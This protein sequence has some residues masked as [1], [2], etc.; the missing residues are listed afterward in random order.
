MDKAIIFRIVYSVLLIPAVYDISK[1]TFLFV[2]D[3]LINKSIPTSIS[4]YWYS[5]VESKRNPN[6]KTVEFINIKQKGEFVSFNLYQHTYKQ[7][8]FYYKG[9]GMMKGVKLVAWFS[10]QEARSD[11]IGAFILA[12]EHDRQHTFYL[13]GYYEELNSEH[14]LIGDIYST[15]PISLDLF[16]KLEFTFSKR[17]FMEKMYDRFIKR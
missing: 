17:K 5:I 14:D 6:N 9:A 11:H 7:E 3:K 13:K 10:N 12:I 2:K 4:G 8:F 16:E 1:A 15:Y